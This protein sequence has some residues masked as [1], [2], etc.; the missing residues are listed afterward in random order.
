MLKY[1]VM[2]GQGTALM[3]LSVVAFCAGTLL[4]AAVGKA[5]IAALRWMV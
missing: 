1:V 3:A 5:C 4:C 2:A